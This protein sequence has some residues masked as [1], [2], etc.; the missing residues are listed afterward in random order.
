MKNK[1]TDCCTLWVQSSATPPA[2]HKKRYITTCRHLQ[3]ECC[4]YTLVLALLLSYNNLQL[5]FSEVTAGCVLWCVAVTQCKKCKNFDSLELHL[6]MNL[7]VR[8]DGKSG[9]HAKCGFFCIILH[10]MITIYAL[11]AFFTGVLS[12]ACGS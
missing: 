4:V 1:N 2:S 11:I 10:R 6:S 7:E 8:F 9:K 5:G 3:F 12:S